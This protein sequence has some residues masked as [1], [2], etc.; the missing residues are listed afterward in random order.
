[1]TQERKG[2][3]EGHTDESSLSP[4]EM[5]I[6]TR[7]SRDEESTDQEKPVA[8]EIGHIVIDL[9]TP[10]SLNDALEQ[11]GSWGEMT[12]AHTVIIATIEL[13]GEPTGVSFIL[14][15]RHS[16]S[17]EK[18]NQQYGLKVLELMQ[19]VNKDFYVVTL[20]ADEMGL[21]DPKVWKD[22]LNSPEI[23]QATAFLNQIG[24]FA[25]NIV[26]NAVD[27]MVSKKIS[28]DNNVRLILVKT[29]DEAQ[30]IIRSHILSR[31][32]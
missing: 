6:L 16:K 14:N 9:D 8:K 17:T 12:D 24:A 26:P 20:E 1:M 27:S 30:K 5:E 28:Q 21:A 7:G 15:A 4:E 22:A 18:V 25:V 13:S 32:S 19:R 2:T 31:S 29:P 23:K 3:N 11:A 10:H